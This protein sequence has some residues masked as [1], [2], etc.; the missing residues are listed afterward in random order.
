MVKQG[1]TVAFSQYDL[2]LT[3]WAFVGPVLLFGDHLGFNQMSVEEK[4]LYIKTFYKVGRDLGKSSMLYLFA[5]SV[6]TK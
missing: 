5:L 3:Q 1:V 6:Q 4:S 2:V